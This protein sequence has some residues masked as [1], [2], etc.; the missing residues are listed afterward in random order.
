MDVHEKRHS[1]WKHQNNF[2]KF[3]CSLWNYIEHT[4]DV[5][6]QASDREC[7]NVIFKFEETLEVIL[8]FLTF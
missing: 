2:I 3:L 5:D 8:L 6:I 1:C 7:E 4:R